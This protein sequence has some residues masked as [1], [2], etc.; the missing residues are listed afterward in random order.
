MHEIGASCFDLSNVSFIS[1]MG[2]QMT[3]F[4][5]GLRCKC[6]MADSERDSGPWGYSSPLSTCLQSL[7]DTH[8]L[9][10]HEAGIQITWNL[11][12]FFTE[13]NNYTYLNSFFFFSSELL[14]RSECLVRRERQLILLRVWNKTL[15]ASGVKGL[16]LSQG[17][18][19]APWL[20]LLLCL[21]TL[22]GCLAQLSNTSSDPKSTLTDSLCH[23][24]DILGQWAFSFL[25]LTP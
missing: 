14:S 16:D 6:K 21:R 22:D 13:I 8:V 10:P 3:S 19:R 25:A 23:S 20:A 12:I 24:Q 18:G 11:L 1:K 7:E 2:R 17:G 9:A 15:A 4:R 5:E